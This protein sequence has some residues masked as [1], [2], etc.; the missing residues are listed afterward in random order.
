MSLYRTACRQIALKHGDFES[1]LEDPDLRFWMARERDK[2]DTFSRLHFC[3]LPSR[4]AWNAN[5]KRVAAEVWESVSLR[6]ETA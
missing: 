1:Y 5:V 4:R 6:R 3:D 2:Y